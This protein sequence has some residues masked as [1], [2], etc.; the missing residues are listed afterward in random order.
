MQR[1]VPQAIK[2][3]ERDSKTRGN[4][5]GNQGSGK[6]NR[7]GSYQ[8]NGTN[9]N[10]ATTQGIR[11]A[12]SQVQCFQCQGRDILIEIVQLLK[13]PKGKLK[14]GFSPQTSQASGQVGQNLQEGLSP[15]MQRQ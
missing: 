12:G 2:E 1:T 15:L 10:Q 9:S 11:R 8:N 5:P 3:I 7:N 4:G 6:N 13:P 14:T